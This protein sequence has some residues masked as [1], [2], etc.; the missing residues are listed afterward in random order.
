MCAISSC[1]SPERIRLTGFTRP[2]HNRNAPRGICPST[3]SAPLGRLLWCTML[4][5]ENF[6]REVAEAVI[7]TRES[8]LFPSLLQCVN[9]CREIPS[10][11]IF[12]CRVVRFRPNRAA[13]PSTPGII[14]R[15]SRKTRAMCSRSAASSV[16]TSRLVSAPVR[17]SASGGRS[18]VPCVR[19]TERSIRFS[20][21][22][23]F[24]GQCQFIRPSWC[25]W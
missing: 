18:T 9:S 22:R 23:T 21:S 10:F 14:P 16:A 17:N 3:N 8:G 24:A 25:R 5:F 20:S 2:E 1:V 15:V 6:R 12:D 11:C 4:L 13:A 7:R 19:I